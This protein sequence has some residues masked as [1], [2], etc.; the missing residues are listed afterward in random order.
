LDE[1]RRFRHLVRNA[2]TM[3]LVPEKMAGLMSALPGLWPTLRAELL[4]F[5]DFLEALAQAKKQ[6]D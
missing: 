6:G 2:Y 4:A 5:A 3:S 1:F